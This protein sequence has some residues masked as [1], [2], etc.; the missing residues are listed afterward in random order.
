M[1][2]IHLDLLKPEGRPAIVWSD[3]TGKQVTNLFCTSTPLTSLLSKAKKTI[4]AN[5]INC[6]AML[7]NNTVNISYVVP[8][9]KNG[10]SVVMNIFDLKG[11]LVKNLFNGFKQP[12]AYTVTSAG[13]AT[14]GCKAGAAIYLLRLAQNENTVTIPVRYK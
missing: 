5:F 10:V 9:G 12:G 4:A 1:D 13:L 11:S 3:V 6:S 7:K 8:P 14:K 2:S